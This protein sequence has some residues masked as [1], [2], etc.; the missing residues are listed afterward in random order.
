M[1]MNFAVMSV[2]GCQSDAGNSYTG[3]HTLKPMIDIYLI[4]CAS[5]KFQG[6]PLQQGHKLHG[7]GKIFVI[8]NGNHHLSWKRYEIGPWLLWNINRNS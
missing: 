4:P 2:D 7:G 3:Y 5:T 8:F 1:H 6:E